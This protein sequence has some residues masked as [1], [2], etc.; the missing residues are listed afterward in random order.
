MKNI[1]S[2]LPVYTHTCNP[3]YSLPWQL[4]LLLGW[5]QTNLIRGKAYAPVHVGLVEGSSNLDLVASP[6]ILHSD[7]VDLSFT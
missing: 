4:Y 6:Y 3:H 7:L 5:L 1:L 2:H